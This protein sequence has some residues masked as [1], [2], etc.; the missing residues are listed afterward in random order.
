MKKVTL[1]ITGMDCVSC[2]FN[3]DGPLEDADGVKESKTNYAKQVTEVTYDEASIT[4]QQ[5]AAIV[6]GAGYIATLVE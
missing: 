2:A 1:K 5:L 4:K 6:K 3:I